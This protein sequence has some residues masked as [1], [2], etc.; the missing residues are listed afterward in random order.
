MKKRSLVTKEASN[1]QHQ[2]QG[3]PNH[4]HNPPSNFPQ[5]QTHQKGGCTQLFKEQLRIYTNFGQNAACIRGFWP[6][7]CMYTWLLAKNP[8]MYT[9]FGQKP[10]Y[11]E[12]I[13]VKS[14]PRVKPIKWSVNGWT[15][16]K[17]QHRNKEKQR[18]SEEYQ[19]HCAPKPQRKTRNV[20]SGVANFVMER[21]SYDLG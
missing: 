2:S 15:Y 7:T 11:I 19:V 20:P 5:H 18:A 3:R 13:V 8:C 4:T 1:K 17:M 12:K 16:Y 9:T 10:A 6:K 14:R 21:N